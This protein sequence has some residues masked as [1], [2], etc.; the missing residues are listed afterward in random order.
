MLT[1]FE[2][3]NSL[4][5]FTYKLLLNLIINYLL[6]FY[7]LYIL[8]Y[9][10]FR[11]KSDNKLDIILLNSMG[12]ISFIIYHYQKVR[13]FEIQENLFMI[14]FDYIIHTLII[15]KKLEIP[16]LMI[17]SSNYYCYFIPNFFQKKLDKILEIFKLL[18]IPQLFVTIFKFISK[19]WIER[20]IAFIYFHLQ[21]K[22]F[23]SHKVD[24]KLIE[25]IL[26]DGFEKLSLEY[27][28]VK[29]IKLYRFLFLFS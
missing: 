17:T 11:Y 10:F 14:I 27:N 3:Y 8:I 23:F 15:D 16:D 5:Y 18:C 12:G 26:Y 20:I 2:N 9:K 7:Y 13:S 4:D 22:D 1:I 29:I 6:V 24:K 21:R 19:K 28:K 25:I